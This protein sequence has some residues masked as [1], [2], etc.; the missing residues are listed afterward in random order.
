[1]ILPNS[2]KWIV[3]FCAQKISGGPLYKPEK[4]MGRKSIKEI[5]LPKQAFAVV[6]ISDIFDRVTKKLSGDEEPA[7]LELG[8]HVR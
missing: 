8:W 4:S 3:E 2:G 5:D 7:R 1:M 6:P